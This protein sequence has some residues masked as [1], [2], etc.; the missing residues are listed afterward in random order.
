MKAALR[1]PAHG[2]HVLAFVPANFVRSQLAKQMSDVL[3][4]LPLR[5]HRHQA[6]CLHDGWSRYQ[7]SKRANELT[8]SLDH[9]ALRLRARV[10]SLSIFGLAKKLSG[11]TSPPDAS[12]M[13][14]SVSLGAF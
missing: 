9:A 13:R 5:P 4:G 6:C 7:E 10:S 12:M 14:C 8:A 3:L 11:V 1:Q 2:H